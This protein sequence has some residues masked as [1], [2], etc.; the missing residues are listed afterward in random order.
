MIRRPPRST[1]FPYTTLFRSRHHRARPYG[2]LAYEARPVRV[3]RPQRYVFRIHAE[4]FPHDLRIYRLV[5]LPRETCE[6]VQES[7]AGFAEPDHRLFLRRPA[8][9]RRLDEYPAA[10]AAQLAA[11]PRLRAA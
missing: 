9:P 8:R 7:V 2:A 5:P 3:A 1:L 4:R 11:V 6:H 10:D